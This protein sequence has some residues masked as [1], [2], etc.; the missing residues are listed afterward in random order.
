VQLADKYFD[1]RSQDNINVVTEDAFKYLKRDK[2]RYDVIY[3]DA[4]LKPS[5]ETDS[6]ASHCV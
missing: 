6:T 1:V 4:F 3:M 5:A 2:T